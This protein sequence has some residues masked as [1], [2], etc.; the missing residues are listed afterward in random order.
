MFK[1]APK[2]CDCGPWLHVPSTQFASFLWFVFCADEAASN[3]RFVAACETRLAE[4]DGCPLSG[5]FPCLLHILHRIVVPI[6]RDGNLLNDLFR[7]GHVLQQSTYMKGLI[8]S[9]GRSINSNIVVMHED[10]IN[11]PRLKS[12]AEAILRLILCEGIG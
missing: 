11:Q 6:M 9:S 5:F 1:L 8:Q 12:I 3:K 10:D 7:A 4:T 2:I